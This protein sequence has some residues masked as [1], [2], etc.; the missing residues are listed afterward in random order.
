VLHSG[1]IAE[2]LPVAQVEQAQHPA[3][4][5]LL[6]ALPVPVGVMLSHCHAANQPQHQNLRIREDVSFLHLQLTTKTSS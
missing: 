2:C 5:S 1:A 6:H 4:L 3:T